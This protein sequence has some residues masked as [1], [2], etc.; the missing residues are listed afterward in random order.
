[1]AGEREDTKDFRTRL[2][3]R[4]VTGKL[5]DPASVAI[6]FLISWDWEHWEDMADKE[7]FDAVELIEKEMLGER[8]ECP[9]CGQFIL[10]GQTCWS[11]EDWTAPARTQEHI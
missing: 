7:Q 1:M 10:P 6:A 9:E 5:S 11:C 2:E 8:V 4:I 3:N